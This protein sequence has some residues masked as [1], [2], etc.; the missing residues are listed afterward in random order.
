MK[1]VLLGILFL[2]FLS[3]CNGNFLSV[4][5]KMELGLKWDGGLDVGKVEFNLDALDG[6]DFNP[7]L[8]YSG[9]GN[10]SGGSSGGEGVL[11][12]EDGTDGDSE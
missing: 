1:K 9:L 11:P 10:D 4:G 3:G 2:I 12:S 5:L 7:S 6:A 8:L